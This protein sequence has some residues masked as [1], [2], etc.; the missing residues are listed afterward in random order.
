[1]ELVQLGHGD[2]GALTRELITRV[3]EPHLG[4][5]MLGRQEDA[6]LFSL[7]GGKVALTTDS[8]VVKPLF[9]PGGDIGKLAVCGTANDLA[10][11]GA[12][13][14][15]LTAGFIIEEGLP[16]EELEQVAL[17]MARAAAAAGVKIVAADTK[18]AERGAVDRLFINTSGIGQREAEISLGAEM[19]RPGDSVIVSGPVGNHG[20]V[21]LASRMGINPGNGLLSDCACLWPLICEIIEDFPIR[22]MRDATRGGLATVL[23]ELAVAAGLD[24]V[25]EE[26]KIP[27]C[28]E[29]RELAEMLGVDPLYLACEGRFIAVVPPEAASAVVERLHRFEEGRGAAIIGRLQEGSGRLLLRTSFGGTRVLDFL[30]GQHIPRIC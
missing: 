13:P 16:L 6:A 22:F 23:K 26:E 30:R 29:V 24:L 12:R 3:F 1:M 5:P 15:Y 21:I 17:S 7:P 10:V 27:L 8:F 9:F 4:N 2:G 20:M 14:L 11:M 18:V 25:V 28:R 19:V